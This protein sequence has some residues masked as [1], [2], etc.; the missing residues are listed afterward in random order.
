LD[1]EADRLQLTVRERKIRRRRT[2][3]PSVEVIGY[4]MKIAGVQPAALPKSPEEDCRFVTRCRG[5]QPVQN[6]SGVQGLI[7]SSY[8]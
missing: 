1:R 8:R 5:I 6:C 4:R 3:N 7:L 2:F